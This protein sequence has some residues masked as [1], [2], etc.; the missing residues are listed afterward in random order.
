MSRSKKQPDSQQ[1]IT[2]HIFVAID[3]KGQWIARGEG[4]RDE[5]DRRDEV[6]PPGEMYSSWL[7][8]DDDSV[9]EIMEVVVEVPVPI[10]KVLEGRLF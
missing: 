5:W 3:E 9:L 4:C 1:F 8:A 2:A 10:T 6:L 7:L